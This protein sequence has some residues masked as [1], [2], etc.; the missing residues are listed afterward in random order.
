MLDIQKDK[1]IFHYD[2]EEVW[3]EPWGANALRIRSTKEHKMP[4][5]NHALYERGMAD[6]EIAYTRQGAEIS[7]GKIRA[8]GSRRRLPSDHAV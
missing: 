8:E 4:E 3:I 6:C 7:N 1:L 5:E 2:A